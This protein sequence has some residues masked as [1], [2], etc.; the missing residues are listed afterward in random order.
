MSNRTCKHTHIVKDSRNIIV[1]DC[2]TCKTEDRKGTET[3]LD[4]IIRAV[5]TGSDVDLILMRN[6][7]LTR[8]SGEAVDIINR[9]AGLR[10]RTRE[11]MERQNG[12][13]DENACKICESCE[14]YPAVFF[15]G[16]HNASAAD[17]NR[18]SAEL[19]R[20]IERVNNKLKYTDK[21]PDADRCMRCI[22]EILKDLT[23]L[24]VEYRGVAVMISESGFD[25]VV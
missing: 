3:C 1:L 10:R 17:L 7:N 11:M 5:E 21:L 6:L 14:L 2:M 23:F 15:E 8:F 4:M 25:V 9:L 13:C 12:I 16:V 20:S 19:G 18:L 24:F 22:G